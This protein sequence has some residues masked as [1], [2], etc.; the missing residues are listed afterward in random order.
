M[1]RRGRDVPEQWGRGAALERLEE[2]R[3]RDRYAYSMDRHQEKLKEADHRRR[4]RKLPRGPRFGL[5]RRVARLIRG[6]G[7]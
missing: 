3:T 2:R 7:D 4:L 5:L 6:G 1:T